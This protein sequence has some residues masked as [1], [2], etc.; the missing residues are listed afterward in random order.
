MAS[1]HYQSHS[2]VPVVC[3]GFAQG[4][5]KSKQQS[6][7]MMFR[8]ILCVQFYRLMQLILSTLL[9]GIIR[10]ECQSFTNHG[11]DK[12]P[13]TVFNPLSLWLTLPR[14]MGV[15]HTQWPPSITRA[16]LACLWF[17]QGLHK[18]QKKSKQQSRSIMFRVILCVQI[19]RLTQLFFQHYLRALSAKNAN[20]LQTT[21]T[22]KRHQRY[23]IRYHCG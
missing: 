9:K 20:H 17:A 22:L 2:C 5:K 15:S 6:R 23:S 13:P 16:I 18:A 3:T 1:Q 12:T 8:V 7:S 10:K 21:D 4:S 14:D 19:Y 11:H